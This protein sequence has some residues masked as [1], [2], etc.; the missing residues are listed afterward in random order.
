MSW[1]KF[2]ASGL[3][4]VGEPAEYNFNIRYRPGTA[5]TDEDALSRMSMNMKSYMNSWIEET[6]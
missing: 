2:N 1:P 5:N 4:W 3:W 6:T